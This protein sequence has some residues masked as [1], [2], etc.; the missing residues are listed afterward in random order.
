MRVRGNRDIL[1]VRKR[2]Q[3]AQLVQHETTFRQIGEPVM[4]SRIIL[5]LLC[6]LLLQACATPEADTSPQLTAQAPTM[7]PGAWR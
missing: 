4:K 2:A 3:E 1:P 7:Y 6:G 5:L